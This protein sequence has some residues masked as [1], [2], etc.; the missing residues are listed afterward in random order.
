MEKYRMVRVQLECYEST[1][2][3]LELWPLWLDIVID[4]RNKP[5]KYALEIYFGCHRYYNETSEITP[6]ILTA[7][8]QKIKSYIPDRNK[9]N[10]LIKKDEIDEYYTNLLDKHEICNGV[11]GIN[12]DNN[13]SKSKYKIVCVRDICAELTEFGVPE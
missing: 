3:P 1:V 7:R 12:L 5:V 13:E 2:T 8:S 11:S 4:E 6:I 10:R 9:E